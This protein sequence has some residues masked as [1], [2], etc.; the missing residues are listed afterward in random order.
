[1]Q[2]GELF[3]SPITLALQFVRNAPWLINPSPTMLLI[4]YAGACRRR[5]SQLYFEPG[6]VVEHFDPRPVKTGNSGYDT[7]PK[8]AFGSAPA[9]FEPVKTFENVLLLLSWKSRPV[10]GNRNNALAFPHLVANFDS[11]MPRF[12][13]SEISR[14]AS[15]PET[16]GPRTAAR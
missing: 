2:V 10:I 14:P 8:P 11:A 12:E 4:S 3:R 7:E 9:S 13:S 1:L 6:P 16:T 15:A 5:K